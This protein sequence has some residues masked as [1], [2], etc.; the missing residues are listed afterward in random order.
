MRDP[1]AHACCFGRGSVGRRGW[2]GEEEDPV[3]GVADAW[4]LIGSG[5]GSGVS[6]RGEAVRAGRWDPAVGVCARAG[7]EAKLG[8]LRG[9]RVRVGRR[10][11]A[12]LA[13]PVEAGW[14]KLLPP[15]FLFHSSFSFVFLFFI[16]FKLIWSL[17]HIASHTYT[18]YM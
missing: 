6:R 5:C 14:A 11:S 7:G 15:S 17:N 12:G 8:R 2:R 9:P 1:G 13:G 3:A 10:G 18:W 4:G 16:C